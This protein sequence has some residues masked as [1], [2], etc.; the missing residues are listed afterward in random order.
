[1]KTSWW[2]YLKGLRY[3]F[4]LL[5]IMLNRRINESPIIKTVAKAINRIWIMPLMMVMWEE[6]G[7]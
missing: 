7:I 6:N 5:N 1:L 4:F 3:Y 2:A